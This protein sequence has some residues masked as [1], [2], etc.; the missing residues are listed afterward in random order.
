MYQPGSISWASLTAG[1]LLEESQFSFT[2]IKGKENLNPL[3]E[4]KLPPENKMEKE[5][6]S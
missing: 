2:E 6:L 3:S 4:S 5:K 1:Q